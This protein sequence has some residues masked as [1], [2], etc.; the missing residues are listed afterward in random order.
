MGIASISTNVNAIPEA[1]KNLETGILIEKGNSIQ[2]AEAI[3]KLKN[4]E[5]LRRK[6]AENGRKF[7][8]ENFNEKIVAEIAFENYQTVLSNNK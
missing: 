4:N 3:E 1:I 2:L 6:L 8:L 5:N 7:V